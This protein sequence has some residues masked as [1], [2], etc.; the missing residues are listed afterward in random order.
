MLAGICRNFKNATNLDNISLYKIKLNRSTKDC[1]QLR[2]TE[3]SVD[4]R[5]RLTVA[6]SRLQSA[7]IGSV[8]FFHTPRRA[9]TAGHMRHTNGPVPAKF[10]S[11]NTPIVNHTTGFVLTPTSTKGKC[12]NH[13]ATDLCRKN[14]SI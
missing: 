2:N 13:F 3:Q 7:V 8:T 4:S 11:E 5:L 9:D 1:H 10:Y 12:S 6:L 14:D